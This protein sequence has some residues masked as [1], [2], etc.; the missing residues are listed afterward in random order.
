MPLSPKQ[1]LSIQEATKR[2]NIWVGSIRAGK[3]F[4]SILKLVDLIKNG[5]PGDGMIIGVNRESIQ[6]NV[7]GELYRFLGFSPPSSKTVQVRL[8]GRDIYFVGAHDEGS[9]R[10]IKGSTLALAY[11]D[12]ATDIP[13]PF[14]RM[15]LGRLSIKGA[16]LLATCNPEGPYHWLKKEF[17]DRKI[18]TLLFGIL[19][20]MTT[21]R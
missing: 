9:V 7:L 16:Q 15:L 10:R 2:I 8:Y 21:R 11:V 5:P 20:S 14:W 4:A 18:L 12:E 1:I 13:S 19:A 3:T 17:I 6:R